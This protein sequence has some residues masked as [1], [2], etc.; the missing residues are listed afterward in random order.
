M[1]IWSIATYVAWGISGLL[2]GWMLFDVIRVGQ[3]YSE[4]FLLSAR[5]GEDELLHEAEEEEGR[6]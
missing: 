4:S 6:Q 2:L 1:T 3:N 5:E